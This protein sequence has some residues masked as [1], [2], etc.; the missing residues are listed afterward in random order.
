MQTTIKLTKAQKSALDGMAVKDIAETNAGFLK[1][2]IKDLPTDK[3]EAIILE[4]KAQLNQASAL[5][6]NGPVEVVIKKDPSQMNF[7]ELVRCSAENQ[8]SMSWIGRM[9]QVAGNRRVIALNS[10][11]T[12]DPDTSIDAFTKNVDKET[13]NGKRM[14]TINQFTDQKPRYLPWNK[15]EAIDPASVWAKLTADEMAVI[16]WAATKPTDRG[17]VLNLGSIAVIVEDDLSNSNW[18]LFKNTLAAIERAKE[19]ED[20][21]VE[22]AKCKAAQYKS[23]DQGEA[24]TQ[25]NTQPVTQTNVVTSRGKVISVDRIKLRENINRYYSLDEIESLCFDL[26]VDFENIGGSSKPGKVLELIQ[27]MERRGRLLELADSCRKFRPHIDF[28]EQY[29]QLN[30]AGTVNVGVINTNGGVFIGGNVNTNTGDFVGRD[31]TVYRR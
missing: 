10:D 29:E 16:Y 15:N 26:G 21:E 5:P 6:N 11:K 28:G 14:V 2:I 31:K 24:H 17:G 9:R 25:D 19:D 22:F 23:F 3:L 8:K 18:R 1:Y 4:A 12:I 7:D 27:Y 30:V 13:W 20:G